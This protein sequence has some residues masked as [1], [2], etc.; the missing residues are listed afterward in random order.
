[1]SDLSERV[2]ALKDYSPRFAGCSRE[3]IVLGL[4]E[5]ELEQTAEFLE[6]RDEL[7]EQESGDVAE[8]KEVLSSGREVSNEVQRKQA[9]LR[10]KRR[11]HQSGF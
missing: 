7:R 9:E 6:R 2:E 10:E 8:L 3:E 4:L 11:S 5:E 1:M